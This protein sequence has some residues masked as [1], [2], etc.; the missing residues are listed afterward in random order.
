MQKKI[1]NLW[2]ELKTIKTKLVMDISYD[3]VDVFEEL[4]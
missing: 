4:I 3:N 1:I 2:D